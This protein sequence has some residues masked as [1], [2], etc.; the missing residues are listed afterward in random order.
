M[1]TSHA[2]HGSQARTFCRVVL[3]QAE[4]GPYSM[5]RNQAHI[6]HHRLLLLLL[7]HLHLHLLVH[8]PLSTIVGGD[9]VGP[10]VLP[11]D[12]N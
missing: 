4:K 6:L 11:L 5:S 9:G 3:Q 12:S 7:F 2:S 8:L 1:G 10:S